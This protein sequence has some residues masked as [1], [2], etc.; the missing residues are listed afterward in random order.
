[1]STARWKA[2][3]G[4]DGSVEAT[5]SVSNFKR[6]RGFLDLPAEIRN[7]IYG[8]VISSSRVLVLGNH[9]QREVEKYKKAHRCRRVP[10]FRYR[11]HSV[12]L[13]SADPQGL[14]AAVAF[15]RACRAVNSE[16]TS[17]LYASTVFC[18]TTIKQI[19]KFLNVLP[20]DGKKV[21]NKI[22]I[23]YSAYGEPLWT[24]D[25]YWKTKSDWKWTMTCTRIER[26]LPAL[27]SVNLGLK[28]SDW[29]LRLTSSASCF[30]PL[31]ILK[32]SGLERVRIRLSHYRF[33]PNRC[34]AVAKGL[35]DMMMT[36]E[37]RELRDIEKA[38]EAVHQMEEQEARKDR[39]PTLRAK[40]AL[41]IK[42]IP[43]VN[44]ATP[45]FPYVVLTPTSIFT[46][47]ECD[48]FPTK[49]A[50]GRFRIIDMIHR[51]IPPATP[52][53]SGKLL[54]LAKDVTADAVWAW[55]LEAKK[56]SGIQALGAL[57]RQVI[58]LNFNFS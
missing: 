9:P 58:E 47:W 4:A 46:V 35:E 3:D 30:E 11:L 23:S 19:N 31:E 37:G 24:K 33:N 8:F 56:Q 26:E 57:K 20:E 27:R 42:D 43:R 25:E 5:S 10:K 36:M 18:F 6:K 21:I 41:V 54:E 53:R 13:S 12:I 50:N 49:A 51:A 7:K 40:K 14:T 32:G 38:I 28:I 48:G 17:L 22:E 16:I 34:A 45:V 39:L 29:P 55:W 2:F 52:N 15:L 44:R 1:M